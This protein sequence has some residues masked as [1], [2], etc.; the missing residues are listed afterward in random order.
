MGEIGQPTQIVETA[1][2]VLHEYRTS[3]DGLDAR[4]VTLP[5]AV[6]ADAN[7]ALAI[8]INSS[9]RQIIPVVRENEEAEQFEHVV[10]REAARTGRHCQRIYVLPHSGFARASLDALI[11]ADRAAGI[12]SRIAI[13]SRVP[14]DDQALTLRGMWILDGDTVLLP[15]ASGLSGEAGAGEYVVSGRS[16]DVITAREAWERLWSYASEYRRDDSFLDLEEPLV[17]SADLLNGVAP[18]LCTG[19]HIDATGCA[20]YH[21]T[22]QYLRLLQMVSTPTWHDEFY[23]TGLQ[24]ALDGVRDPRV[25]IT[26][27]ADYSLLAYVTAALMKTGVSGA[28]DVIDLCA[29]PLFGC[30]WFA[31]RN[32]ISITTRQID[33]RRIFATDPYSYDV[34]CSDAFLTRFQK[35]EVQHLLAGFR[36][37]LRP[38]GRFITTIRLHSSSFV[39]RDNEQ[40]IADF[41][42]RAIERA[43]RWEPFLRKTAN[44]IGS[45]A[46]DYA[47][48][49]KSFV[50]GDERELRRLITDS[51]FEIE[52]AELADVPGEL[53][54][55]VYLR[56]VCR[57]T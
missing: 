31:K 32:G 38:N 13:V 25:A 39:T 56:V 6:F 47:R 1:R 49:M 29:T 22:W 9:A 8:A 45:L 16:T 30:R 41:R 21:G 15:T 42:Q 27:T 14:V 5:R 2:N 40:L 34:A 28:V 20:W 12:T 48:R 19:D 26:G 7:S 23:R 3:Q 50:L 53:T 43:H 33:V 10:W 37:I 4:V 11:A 24:Q 46:E 52:H 17:S 35:D 44:E 36:R 55:T 54:P 51:G 18:V 57:N